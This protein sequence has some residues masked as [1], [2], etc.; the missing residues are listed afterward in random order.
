MGEIL[1]TEHSSEVDEDN[2]WAETISYG[3]LE[4]SIDVHE[5]HGHE[6]K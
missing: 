2:L 4:T 5:G 6:E 1:S 3:L